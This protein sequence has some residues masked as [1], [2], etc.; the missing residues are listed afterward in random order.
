MFT[1]TR[2]PGPQQQASPDSTSPGATEG[3]DSGSA[4]LLHDHEHDHDHDHGVRGEQDLEDE[5]EEEAED[6]R[7]GPGQTPGQGHKKRKRRV[8]FSKVRTY[9]WILKLLNRHF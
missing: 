4:S 6:E 9:W 5:L 7:G 2:F 8:L 1:F 3:T